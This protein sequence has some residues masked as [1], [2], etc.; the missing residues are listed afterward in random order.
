MHHIETLNKILKDEL[1]AT[2]MYHQALDKLRDDVGL[3]ESE[4]LRPIYENHKDVIFSLQALPTCHARL[5]TPP[6][7]AQPCSTVTSNL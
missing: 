6:A 5:S 4:S 3:D 1:S 7:S 2:E